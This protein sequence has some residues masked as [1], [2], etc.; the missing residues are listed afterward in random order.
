VPLTEISRSLMDRIAD[1]VRSGIIEPSRS[2]KA[3][4]LPR[5]FRL[6]PRGLAQRYLAE[7]RDG[8]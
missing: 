3:R 8:R 4:K 7:D 1:L 6:R 2:T 5:A